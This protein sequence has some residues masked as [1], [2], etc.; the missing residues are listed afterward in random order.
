M[1]L[2]LAFL[3]LISVRTSRMNGIRQRAAYKTQKMT[4]AAVNGGII[5]LGENDAAVCLSSI[6]VT[7]PE[8]KKNMTTTKTLSRS[9]KR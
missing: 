6:A 1:V 3:K 5:I 4:D 9:S 2:R 8:I 7:Q